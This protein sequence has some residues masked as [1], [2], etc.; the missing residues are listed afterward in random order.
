[1]EKIPDWPITTS[2]RSAGEDIDQGN[3]RNTLMID[4][5]PNR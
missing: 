3:V 1:M 4:N 5:I 2:A